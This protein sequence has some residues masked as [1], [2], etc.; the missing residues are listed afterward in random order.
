MLKEDTPEQ[1]PTA[2]TSEDGRFYVHPVTS[3]RFP[4]VTTILGI[5]AKP[6]LS[7]WYG[8]LAALQ[9]LEDLG[10]VK[11]LAT[12]PTC[13]DGKCGD[14]FTCYIKWVSRAGDRERDM[15]G[16]IGSRV[17]HVAEHYALDGM[18]LPHRPDIARHVRQFLRF[19]ERY[20]PTWEAT[21]VTVLNRT[22]GWAGTLDGI[23]IP[24]W[25][26]KRLQHLVGKPCLLDYKTNR[27]VDYL[28]AYQ[29]AA[30]RHAEAVLLP[31]GT[32][33]PMPTMDSETALSVQIRPHDYWVRP[34][35]VSDAVYA[36]FLR[37]RDVWLDSKSTAGLLGYAVRK[38]AK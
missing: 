4:S 6:Y 18:I 25:M 5:V 29:V 32:E 9:A 16:D 7:P 13:E 30:Y 36:R 23:I 3:E 26:P 17:H 1:P 28:A 21:E 19:V 8:K 34:V 22:D 24:G 12:L 14:C 37:V 11:R 38:D 10:R 35:D 27:H 33:L 31:D 20:R 15:L 2:I